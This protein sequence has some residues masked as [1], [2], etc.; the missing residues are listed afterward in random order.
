[1]SAWP[2]IPLAILGVLALAILTVR[3]VSEQWSTATRTEALVSADLTPAQIAKTLGG[4]GGFGSWFAG[5][6]TAAWALLAFMAYQ[7]V[8]GKRT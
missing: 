8:R 2:L 7:I 4:G 5:M 3:S 6:G 1:L